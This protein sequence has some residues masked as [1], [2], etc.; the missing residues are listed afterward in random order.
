MPAFVVFTD[1]TL[2]AIA[3]ALP[4]TRADLLTIPGVGRRKAERYADDVL[5]ILTGRSR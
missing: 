4:D 1:A 2:T 3:E 5:Q